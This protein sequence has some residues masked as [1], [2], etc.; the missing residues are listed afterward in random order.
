MLLNHETGSTLFIPNNQLMTQ[1]STTTGQ[2][3]LHAG[4]QLDNQQLACKHMTGQALT[5]HLA[6]SE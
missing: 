1:G 2:K 6:L 5:I 3:H 4:T